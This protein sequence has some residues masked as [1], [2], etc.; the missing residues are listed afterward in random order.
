[1]THNNDE[2]VLRPYNHSVFSIRQHYLTTFPEV[3]F[4][5]MPDTDNPFLDDKQID[6]S[7]IYKI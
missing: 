7:K 2:T 4:Q 3:A 6:S 5:R 1:M